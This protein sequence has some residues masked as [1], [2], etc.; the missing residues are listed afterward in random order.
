MMKTRHYTKDSC[1]EVV[2]QLHEDTL[3]EYFIH[4]MAPFTGAGRVVVPKGTR[5]KMNHYMNDDYF[6]ASIINSS[7]QLKIY[8]KENAR[9]GR[10][11]GRCT[12]ITF[13]IHVS[14]L[15]NPSL[16]YVKGDIN[17]FYGETWELKENIFSVEGDIFTRFL[18]VDAKAIFV[19][20]GLTQIRS[21]AVRYI[22]RH[23]KELIH[24]I[25]NATHK[26]YSK[27]DVKNMVYD[28]LDSLYLQGARRIAM[29]GIKS[30]AGSGHSECLMVEAVMEWIYQRR[31]PRNTVTIF[32]VDLRRGFVTCKWN[33]AS[34]NF[35]KKHGF[36]FDDIYEMEAA[37]TE[38]LQ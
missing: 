5:F 12:G 29:N 7:L 14:L 9:E 25:P 15:K 24:Y 19:P 8:E 18:L 32:L 6:Y 23:P 26:V 1:K 22:H 30:V 28:A 21:A 16:I 20:A 2:I 3:L 10:L 4:Y 17:S 36:W 27:D 35:Y 31:I 34:S 33:I 37:F 38:R 13:I 11:K